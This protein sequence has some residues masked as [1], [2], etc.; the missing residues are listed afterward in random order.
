MLKFSLSRNK[1]NTSKKNEN[2]PRKR[3]PAVSRI[4]GDAAGGKPNA[5]RAA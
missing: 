5:S 4:L 3:Q 2:R 1:R